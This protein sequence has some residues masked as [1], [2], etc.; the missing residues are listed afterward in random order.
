MCWSVNNCLP[1]YQ[2][3][4]NK[5]ESDRVEN[6]CGSEA[7]QTQ[8]PVNSVQQIDI[9]TD[10]EATSSRVAEMNEAFLRVA[11]NDSELIMRDM[12]Q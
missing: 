8:V 11:E 1:V 4:S 3:R 12:I 7:E 6:G 9:P 2:D 5:F 10:S